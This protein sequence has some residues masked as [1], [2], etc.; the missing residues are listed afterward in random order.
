MDDFDDVTDEERRL[1]A[2]LVE[3]LEEKSERHDLPEALT[4][5]LSLLTNIKRF[6][7]DPGAL[8]RGR[9]EIHNRVEKPENGRDQKSATAALPKWRLLYWLPLPAVAALVLV[10]STLRPPE[11]QGAE[12]YEA[13]RMSEAK[14]ANTPGTTNNSRGASLEMRAASS[15]DHDEAGFSP[16]PSRYHVGETP[17]ALLSAQAAVLAARDP[18]QEKEK[19]RDEFER[20]MRA[21]RG[22]LIASLEVGGR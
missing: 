16:L 10:F 2:A 7:L 21:Y 19:A 6:E 13:G 17:R 5:P 11:K 15:A 20:Q 18:G 3:L 9:A 22:Q 1:A 12:T 8:T 4:A 14:R